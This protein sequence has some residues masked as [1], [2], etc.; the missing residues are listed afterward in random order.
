MVRKGRGKGKLHGSVRAAYTLFE[1]LC[2]L[3]EKQEQIR[4]KNLIRG[5]PKIMTIV[6]M[7]FCD[8]ENCKNI[9]RLNDSI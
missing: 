8:M 2:A 1:V 3:G 5:K 7:E 4:F 9:K 6:K